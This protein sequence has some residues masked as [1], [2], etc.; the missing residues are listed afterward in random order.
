M[1]FS[2]VFDW[3]MVHIIGP[4]FLILMLCFCALLMVGL[5]CIPSCIMK[6]KEQEQRIEFCYKQKPRT[7][8]CEYVLWK[9]ELEKKQPRHTTTAVPVVMP[10]VR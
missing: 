6:E 4:F 8:E 3:C 2:D 10:I 5:F 1:D 9:Y 7:E